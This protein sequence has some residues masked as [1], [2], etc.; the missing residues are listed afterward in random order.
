MVRMNVRMV[1]TGMY[2]RRNSV[3]MVVVRWSHVAVMGQSY[4]LLLHQ[5]LMGKANFAIG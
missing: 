1:M 5:L 4:L 2:V 3:R